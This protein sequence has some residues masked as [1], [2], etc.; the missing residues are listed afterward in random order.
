MPT[1][2]LIV[3]SDADV[4][5]D[6]DV[7][8][9]VQGLDEARIGSTSSMHRTK[10][11]DSVTMGV[12]GGLDVAVGGNGLVHI[13]VEAVNADATTVVISQDTSIPSCW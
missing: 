7:D 4:G 3:D 13:G 5:K 10:D 1:L 11:G 6:V 12:N 8:K 2:R 9:S